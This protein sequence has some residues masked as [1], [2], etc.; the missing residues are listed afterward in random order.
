MIERLVR[1]HGVRIR[2]D[3]DEHCGSD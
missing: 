1:E 2:K 3:W